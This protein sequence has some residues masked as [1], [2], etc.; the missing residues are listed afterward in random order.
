MACISGVQ[1]AVAA[2]RGDEPV[3]GRGQVCSARPAHSAQHPQAPQRIAV[4]GRQAVEGAR[5]RVEVIDGQRAQPRRGQ[6]RDAPRHERQ[7]VVD[8]LA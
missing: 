3:E 7:H 4:G 8:R 5:Q 1:R 2:V 6:R